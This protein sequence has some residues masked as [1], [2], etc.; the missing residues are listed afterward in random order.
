MAG[1]I[2]ADYSRAVV[3]DLQI[4][5]SVPAQHVQKWS[6]APGDIR[7]GAIIFLTFVLTSALSCSAANKRV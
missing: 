1:E 3:P 7:N 2:S 5:A 6:R 4:A